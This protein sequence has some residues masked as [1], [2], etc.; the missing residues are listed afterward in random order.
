MLPSYIKTLA[1]VKS[2]T[3]LVGD[4]RELLYI[5]PFPE[6]LNLLGFYVRHNKEWRHLVPFWL[7]KS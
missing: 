6:V 2:W 5:N 3:D 4:G 7:V 1:S